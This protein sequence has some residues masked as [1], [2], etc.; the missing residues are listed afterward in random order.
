M[1][2]YL[3]HLDSWDWWSVTCGYVPV[4]DNAK[5]EHCPD[6]QQLL[7]NLY[8]SQIQATKHDHNPINESLKN[9]LARPCI[10]YL[11][12]I[13]CVFGHSETLPAFICYLRSLI[14][15]H[16][17]GDVTKLL[18]LLQKKSYLKWGFFRDTSFV[19]VIL[20]HKALKCFILLKANVVFTTNSS[21]FAK[22]N[23]RMMNTEP[24]MWNSVAYII[25]ISRTDKKQLLWALKVCKFW[26]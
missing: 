22:K 4:L 5:Q 9:S 1:R 14:C 3:K 26:T 23:N 20:H 6:N 18:G 2:I 21:F 12:F 13:A 17:Q 8:H 19:F 15:A 11:L 10:C 25:Q 16:T 7:R 24:T